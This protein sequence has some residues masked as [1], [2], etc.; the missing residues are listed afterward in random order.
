LAA[1]SCRTFSAL[2]DSHS[3]PL[4][5]ICKKIGPRFRRGPYPPDPI[6]ASTTGEALV[7][8]NAADTVQLTIVPYQYQDTTLTPEDLQQE[9]PYLAPTHLQS[10]TLPSSLTS[11]SFTDQTQSN[12]WFLSK[13][14][15]YQF[16]A[17]ANDTPLLRTV[18]MTFNSL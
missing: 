16:T 4:Q 13:G 11:L 7:F 17:A 10:V 9:A 12:L 18:A 15:L 14:N 5:C 2:P 8:H 6:D 1:A 3:R